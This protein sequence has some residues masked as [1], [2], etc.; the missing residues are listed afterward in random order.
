MSQ[1]VQPL[2]F[3]APTLLTA[4][5]AKKCDILLV[6]TNIIYHFRDLILCNA[7]R[8][9]FNRYKNTV[10]T[11]FRKSSFQPCCIFWFD[12]Y[13]GFVCAIQL[14][15][16]CDGSIVIVDGW[17]IKMIL[18]KYA[19]ILWSW[20]WKKDLAHPLLI[21]NVMSMFGYYDEFTLVQRQI[22]CQLFL[23]ENWINYYKYHTMNQLLILM[24]LDVFSNIKSNL[25][26]IEAQFFTEVK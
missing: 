9:Q 3:K 21:S 24:T 16:H 11:Q 17:W 13:V 14:F 25:D 15:S 1:G 4:C 18:H 7:K 10:V 26:C 6:E 5:S 19:R 20:I 12:G 22:R 8:L 23:K 2:K